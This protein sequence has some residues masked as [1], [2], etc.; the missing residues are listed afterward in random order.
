MSAQLDIS[1]VSVGDWQMATVRGELDMASSS[2]LEA[3]CTALSGDVALDLA[4]VEF[5][6][7]SGLSSLLRLSTGDG[8]FVVL[9]PSVA[10]LRLFDIAKVS[11]RF[12][13]R[14]ALD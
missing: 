10:V 6:D 5:I 7:S 1:V 8:R 2:D 4:G 12:D 11:D 3:A 14:N 9:N 13:I